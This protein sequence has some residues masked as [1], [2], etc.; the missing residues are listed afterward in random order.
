MSRHLGK[1][2]CSTS[3]KFKGVGQQSQKKQTAKPK[4]PALQAKSSCWSHTK[5]LSSFFFY[6]AA[7]VSTE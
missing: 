2:S 1:E 3:F 7:W 6:Y 4:D 5:G